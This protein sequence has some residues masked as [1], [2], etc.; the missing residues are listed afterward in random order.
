MS[1][2]N[3]EVLR[4]AKSALDE[5]L[6]N[7][8]DYDKIK[9]SFLRAQ[10]IKAGLDAGFIKEEEY[11]NVKRSFLESLSLNAHSSAPGAAAASANGNS[12]PA[13]PAPAAARAALQPAPAAPPPPRSSLV[14]R[15][16][17]AAPGVSAMSSPQTSAPPSP[18]RMG[19]GAGAIPTNIPNLGGR[20]PKQAQSKSMSGIAVSED[21]VNMYY[22]LK[23]KSTY[24]WASWIINSAGNEVVIAAVGDKDSTYADFVASF[25]ENDCRYGVYDYQFTNSEGYVFNKLVFLN[26]APD[27]ARTKAKMMYAST[28]DF[29]K[30]FL[31]G[32]SVELQAS[33]LDDITEKD[34]A[35]AVRSSVTRQ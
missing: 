14:Q 1:G 13:V 29:F 35:D 33:D 18:V 7:D 6:I 11:A 8:A 19:A 20:R 3:Y 27:T 4:T 31:D 21:A 16:E 28:K 24:R 23:A 10:Q 26:W 5:G 17:P 22:Y 34:I 32:I 15:A 9:C 25:P 2:G 12:A 30:G